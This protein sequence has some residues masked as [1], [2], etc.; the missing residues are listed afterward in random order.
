M[1]KLARDRRSLTTRRKYALGGAEEEKMIMRLRRDARVI[2]LS[3]SCC[4]P[5]WTSRNTMPVMTARHSRN[6]A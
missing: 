2:Q 3:D 1:Q 5:R 4:T 6:T